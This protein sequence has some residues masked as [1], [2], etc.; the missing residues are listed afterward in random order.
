MVAKREM[1]APVP[2]SG[3]EMAHYLRDMGLELALLSEYAGYPRA[4]LHFLHAAGALGG[5]GDQDPEAKAATEEA[6]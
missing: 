5:Q 4:A 2:A 1:D 3:R 6:T